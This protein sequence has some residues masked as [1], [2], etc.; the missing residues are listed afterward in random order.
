M[1]LSNTILAVVLAAAPA[2]AFSQDWT[3]PYAGFQ[4]GGSEIDTDGGAELD[5]DGPSYGI[6][7]GYNVANGGIVYGGEVDYDV[8]EYDIGDGAVEVDSTTRLKARVG[9][10]VGTG[11][12]YGTAG[13]VWATSPELG[14]DN[15]YL[16]GIGYDM[17]VT[18]NML[19]GAELLSHKFD[20]YNDSGIDVGVTTLKAR[21]SFSF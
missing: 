11:M 18:E 4:I 16:F 6:F 14:D 15:G 20:D 1:K 5:G 2:A 10:A 8:T 12:A 13:I 17:P 3:G 21:V 19:V 9:T 7:A